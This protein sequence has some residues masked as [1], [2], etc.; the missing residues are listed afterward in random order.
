MLAVGA[1]K[2]AAVS[3]GALHRCPRAAH[4]AGEGSVFASTTDRLRIR[5]AAPLVDEPGERGA[6]LDTGAV[7]RLEL[8]LQRK[9]AH[10]A[11]LD[12]ELAAVARQPQRHRRRRA[13]GRVEHELDRE[14][15]VVD[16]LVA[17]A[18]PRDDPA[19]TSRATFS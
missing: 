2:C 15:H 12:R 19:A 17:E 7:Q 4:A 13:A 5:S 14:L 18:E 16:R 3:L 8:L 1:Q 10:P 6:E 9:L 11:D